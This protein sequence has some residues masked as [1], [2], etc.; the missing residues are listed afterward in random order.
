MQFTT[1]FIVLATGLA[2]L[3]GA[4]PADV[5]VRPP[6]LCVV[7]DLALTHTIMLA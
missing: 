4:A 6:F 3:V 5:K 7:V 2:T 1:T